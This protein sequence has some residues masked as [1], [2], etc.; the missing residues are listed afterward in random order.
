MEV[1]EPG[2]KKSVGD[3]NVLFERIQTDKLSY[4]E[5]WTRST[6]DRISHL[7]RSMYPRWGEPTIKM[8][9]E[10]TKKFLYDDTDDV[11]SKSGWFEMIQKWCPKNNFEY[12]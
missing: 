7:I 2:F 5:K 9:T 10:Y 8:A 1:Y 11:W 3:S 4:S 6:T 12:E